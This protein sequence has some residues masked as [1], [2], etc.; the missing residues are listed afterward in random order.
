MWPQGVCWLNH[1]TG[2]REAP[3]RRVRDPATAAADAVA[4]HLRERSGEPVQADLA[5]RGWRWDGDRRCRAVHGLRKPERRLTPLAPPS[6]DTGIGSAV[7]WINLTTLLLRR[8]ASVCPFAPWW[9]EGGGIL[10]I[11]S[12]IGFNRGG[13]T[14]AAEADASPIQGAFG[15]G[16]IRPAPDRGRRAR[17]RWGW[18]PDGAKAL[19]IIPWEIVRPQSQTGSPAMDGRH[20]GHIEPGHV[21]R[22][23]RHFGQQGGTAP[24]AV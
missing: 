5:K 14:T 4:E 8:F 7:G 12:A 10:R 13:R 9:P 24:L 6:M 18:H 3:G 17:R 1:E 16:T 21:T 23:D 19:T 15:C 22:L 11:P 20:L 2:V